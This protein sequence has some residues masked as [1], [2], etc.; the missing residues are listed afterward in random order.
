MKYMK[1]MT[2]AILAVIMVLSM[3][4]AASAA[5][6]TNK[7]EEHTYDAYQVLS[8]TQAKDN[9]ALGDIEWGT[10]VDDEALLKQLKKDYDYFDSCSTAAEVAVV[11]ETA[12]EQTAAAEAL[13]NAAADNLTGV[14]T[15]V[16]DEVDLAA[17]Y[18]LFVDNTNVGT[19]DAR[20]TALLQI[21]NNDIVIDKKYTAPTVDK[22]I[23]GKGEAADACIGDTLT[24]V[25]TATMPD[26]LSDYET[27]KVVFHDTMSKGLDYVDNSLVIKHGEETNSI[28]SDNVTFAKSGGD[29][30]DT[31]IEVSIGDVKKLNV[32]DNDTIIIEYQA[33]VNA[34]AVIGAAGN[35]NEVYLEY[36]NDPNWDKD[37]VTTEPTGETKEDVVVVFVYE[38]DVDKVNKDGIALADAEFVLW[39][40]DKSK[41]AKV[42]EGKLVEWVI[43]SAV[44]KNE[45]GIYPVD[46]TLKSDVN[47]EFSIAGL[48]AGTYYLE[49]TKAP[50]GYNKLTDKIKIVI[51]ADIT[52]EENT[53]SLDK[54]TIAVDD[55]AAVDGVVVDKKYT[56]VVKTAVVNNIGATLPE[57]GG[58]GT[59]IFYIAGAV[60]VLGAVVLLVTKRRMKNE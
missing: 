29:G 2:A 16:T 12:V 9:I 34:D 42:S 20:N 22:T 44:T 38:L 52:D 21:T 33:T 3:A 7:T 47:G 41:I 50:A 25:L 30:S 46:Y 36:S 53:Q 18:W 13:A 10:G 8:G 39:N 32:G 54:L 19:G 27:Y 5:T 55:K 28:D 14:Y 1:K 24:F 11:L 40:S 45:D 6:V 15:P 35:P 43:E 23:Q 37:K 48:D 51:A 57:T 4:M 26:N 17:G 59:T 58:I 49:E 60:L 56:G 31:T